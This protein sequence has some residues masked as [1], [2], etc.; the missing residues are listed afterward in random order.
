MLTY[1][2][3]KIL[4]LISLLVTG[5]S[6]VVVACEPSISTEFP[7]AATEPPV[8]TQDCI[9]SITELVTQIS[10]PNNMPQFLDIGE[11][12]TEISAFDN[13]FCYQD[14]E[15]AMI[16]WSQNTGSVILRAIPRDKWLA[17]GGGKGSLGYPT[18]NDHSKCGTNPFEAN[19]DEFQNGS[20][21]WNPGTEA[22][23]VSGAIRDKYIEIGSAALGIP[24]TDEWGTIDGIGRF[25]HFER[26]SIYWSP[27][28]GAYEVH[29]PIR[30]RWA[31]TNPDPGWEAS[32]LGYPISDVIT[33]S[34]QL[35]F[36]RFQNGV[37]IYSQDKGA[38]D[39]KIDRNIPNYG[40]VLDS[41]EITQTRS[42]NDDTDYVS[43]AVKLP[44]QKE[45]VAPLPKSMG[46]VDN[47]LHY[48]D[49]WVAPIAV[50][51]PNS[52]IPFNYTIVNKSDGDN[53]FVTLLQKTASKA[54]DT[55]IAGLSTLVDPL[56]NFLKGKC[57][58][59]VAAD[60]FAP[61]GLM[62][63]GWTSNAN[64]IYFKRIKYPGGDAPALCNTNNS[65]YYVTWVIFK[66]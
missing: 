38:V 55:Y 29:G 43:F 47:G 16:V 21:Y 42:L 25:N 31:N 11:R 4:C 62:L 40:I 46:N 57:D 5:C 33:I 30:D 36:S 1:S 66:L 45:V 10:D 24:T 22:Y 56:I 37:I 65:E 49:L 28:T 14:F 9:N 12:K 61:T 51:D 13:N 59:V 44:I 39:I 15:K 54:A 20:I 8:P 53:I 48:I 19:C 52:L 35:Q 34:D 27:T 58:G 7:A 64:G 2:P 60:N 26:G 23:A 32:Y 6:L 17:L 18:K 63:E 50:Q 41:F 3:T